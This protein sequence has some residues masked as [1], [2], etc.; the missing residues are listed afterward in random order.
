MSKFICA[1][2]NI[3]IQC[4]LLES[5]DNT[6][7][8]LDDLIDLLDKKQITLLLPEVIE[9]EFFKVLEEKSTKI[10]DKITKHGNE[11]SAD[12]SLRDG[13]KK[14]FVIK[15]QEFIDELERTKT[16][17][18]KKVQTIFNHKETLKLKITPDC[19]T[20]AYKYSI[21]KEKPF[22][23]NL[24]DGNGSKKDYTFQQDCLIVEIL[25]SFLENKKDYVFYFCSDNSSDFAEETNVNDK[26]VIHNDIKKNFFHIELYDNLFD[27]FNSKF[28]TTYS[29]TIIEEAKKGT[30][31]ISVLE[32][33]SPE[34]FTD[35]STQES[36]EKLAS[37]KPI[38]NN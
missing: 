11:F 29:K 19:I 18:L 6:V 10:K 16:E 15:I 34:I 12:G 17:T 26:V 2:T 14:K 27:L 35:E 30:E 7:K 28:D 24:Q 31:A 25:K 3:F 1:D 38:I 23:K 5:A 22:S 37:P 4:C 33:L 8:I 20:Q 13:T 21:H 9:L 36:E 32:N